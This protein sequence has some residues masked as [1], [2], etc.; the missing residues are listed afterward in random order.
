MPDVFCIKINH[1]YQVNRQC[2]SSY[3]IKISPFTYHDK[4]NGSNILHLIVHTSEPTN[5]WESTS[6][7][8]KNNYDY[9][10]HT[11][12]YNYT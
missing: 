11:F 6:N 10:I 3:T 1:G 8:L 7:P 4:K 12:R 5:K 2:A 9:F